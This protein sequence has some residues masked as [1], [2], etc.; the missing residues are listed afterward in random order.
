VLSKI[1]NLKDYIIDLM[2][3]TIFF[4]ICIFVKCDVY[5]CNVFFSLFSFTKEGKILL[6]SPLVKVMVYVVNKKT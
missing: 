2:V 1:F 4:S 6:S 5:K 3:C